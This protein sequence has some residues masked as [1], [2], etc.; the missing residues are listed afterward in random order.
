MAV[1]WVKWDRC[2][3]IHC[4]RKYNGEAVVGDPAA[5]LVFKIRLKLCRSDAGSSLGH[6]FHLRRLTKV[7]QLS[8]GPKPPHQCCLSYHPH[9]LL[10]WISHH[11]SLSSPTL[12]GELLQG[13]ISLS[14][15]CPCTMGGF[16]SLGYFQP[17]P[18]Q[19]PR[20]LCA[21]VCPFP[22]GSTLLNGGD[23]WNTRGQGH[24]HKH[25]PTVIFHYKEDDMLSN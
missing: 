2:L 3:E 20:Q 24:P 23:P 4:W 18:F 15:N 9:W 19:A 1:P 14:H 21:Q 22:H 5:A 6:E 11:P 13:S 10:A 12:Q 25:H 16:I 7:S 17:S 8:R